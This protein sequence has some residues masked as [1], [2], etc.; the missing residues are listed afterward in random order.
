[1]GTWDVMSSHYVDIHSPPP[2]LSSFTKIR[3]GWISPEQAVL[4]RP[5]E[6]K[7][8]LLSPLS[9]GGDTLAIKIP[10]D[11][12]RYYLVENRQPIGCDRIQPDSGI[13]ILKVDP[14][15]QEGAGTA[16]IMDAD[17][18]SPNFSHA[19]FRL[20]REKRRLFIDEDNGV[21][22]LPLWSHGEK[23]GLLVTTP[24]KSADAL[25]AAL[26][27]TRMWTRSPEPKGERERRLR[28][29]CVKAFREFHFKKS[30]QIARRALK[31]Q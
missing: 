10:L 31:E 6:T 13:L 18:A 8:A 19:T 15:A 23:Q 1:M 9:R 4:V 30:W 22:I 14:W 21:A 12:G 5:G 11:R 2:G 24:E 7:G 28:E 3:L 25:R 16:R 17:P 20:D 29:A 27:I 26:M